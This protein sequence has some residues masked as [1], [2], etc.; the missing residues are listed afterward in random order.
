MYCRI[1][2]KMLTFSVENPSDLTELNQWPTDELNPGPDKKTKINTLYCIF[3]VFVCCKMKYI[4]GVFGD[5]VFICT[6]FFC[7]NKSLNAIQQ[8]IYNYNICTF[9]CPW[10]L[11]FPSQ[12]SS[13]SEPFLIWFSLE[14]VQDFLDLSS[15]TTLSKEEKKILISMLHKANVSR[16]DVQKE[17]TSVLLV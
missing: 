13:L 10:Y 14:M 7:R 2:N 17:H 16:F 11:P 4:W 6:K 3:R 1:E 8:L 12:P 5:F 9:C 15:L